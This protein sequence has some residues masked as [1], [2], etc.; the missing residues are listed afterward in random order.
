MDGW[1]DDDKSTKDHEISTQNYY[2]N[3]SFW[4]DIDFRFSELSFPF[5][6]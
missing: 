5:A 6:G 2:G 1:M 4:F 3:D